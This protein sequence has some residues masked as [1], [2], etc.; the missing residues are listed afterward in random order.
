MSDYEEKD[1]SVTG[2]T[3]E[4]KHRMEHLEAAKGRINGDAEPYNRPAHYVEIDPK[5][6]ARLR[7]K[8]DV[9][10]VPFCT[11]LYL[12][13]ADRVLMG[14]DVHDELEAD[15]GA[16]GALH[17]IVTTSTQAQLY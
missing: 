9:R 11:L 2:M 17:D 8:I 7:R 16:I 1:R 5:A 3:P 10:L 6:E 12:C 4:E 13:V 14:Q 15:G